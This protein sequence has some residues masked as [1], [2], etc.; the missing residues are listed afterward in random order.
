[1]RTRRLAGWSL[2]IGVLAVGSVSPAQDEV[3]IDRG[4]PGLLLSFYEL[5]QSPQFLPSSPPASF[6]T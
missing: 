1:M 3:L 2:V 5:E 6:R 4:A